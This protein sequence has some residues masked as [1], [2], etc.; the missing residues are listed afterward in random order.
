MN[1][2]AYFHQKSGS[3]ATLPTPPPPTPF[4]SI[5]LLTQTTQWAGEVRSGCGPQ[6]S[7]VPVIIRIGFRSQAVKSAGDGGFAGGPDLSLFLIGPLKSAGDGGFAG[8]PDLSLFLSG[9]SL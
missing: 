2:L 8:G 7:V 5:S 9:Q 4:H 1:F 6:S 3:S